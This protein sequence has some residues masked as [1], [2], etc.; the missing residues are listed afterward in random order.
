MKRFLLFA[1]FTFS[2][3]SVAYPQ[4]QALQPSGS[5][6]DEASIT[7]M[8]TPWGD[9]QL[10]NSDVDWENAFGRRFDD[11]K[12]LNQ[13]KTEV[14]APTIKNAEKTTLN[15]TVKVL[16]ADIAIA[17][18]YW[19]VTGQT[20]D[21][22]KRLAAVM[23]EQLTSSARSKESGRSWLKELQSCAIELH[24]RHLAASVTRHVATPSL[25]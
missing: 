2:G 8:L 5:S 4:N 11:L 23:A 13:F 7:Q 12:A 17:D 16:S 20:D 22:G 10:Y 15:L 18:R 9:T 21:A 3:V 14:L 1:L 6:A 24:Q 19:S 25:S